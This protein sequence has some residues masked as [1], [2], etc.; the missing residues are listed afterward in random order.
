MNGKTRSMDRCGT[1]AIIKADERV[2]IAG[3]TGSG[4]TWLARRLLD[5]VE[6]LIVIDPKGTFGGKGLKVPNAFDWFQ[7]RRGQPGR[8]RILPPI[9]DNPLV[10]YE[11]LFERLYG[12]GN[13]TLYIDEAYEVADGNRIGKWLKA[14]Y[15]RG[16]ELG[17][18]VWA[19]TQRPTGIPL[20][21]ISESEWI[22]L[23]RMNLQDDRRRIASIAGDEVMQRIPD[24]HGFWLYYVENGSPKYFRTAVQNSRTDV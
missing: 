20:F 14:L 15:T 1:M 16:R 5:P 19:A 3:K 23:F 10:W 7:F 4:K 9:V 17:I 8:F 21:L 22:I 13:L 18:G 6:R 11:E 2:F 24:P 12:Y